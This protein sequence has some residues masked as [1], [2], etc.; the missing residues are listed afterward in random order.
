MLH[1]HY[2]IFPSMRYMTIS[3]PV[4]I[5]DS[6]YCYDHWIFLGG[7]MLAIH[8]DN[9]VQ[10]CTVSTHHVQIVHV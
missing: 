4:H 5:T 2:T 8:G 3:N 1:M 7:L 6:Y 9:L 10:K